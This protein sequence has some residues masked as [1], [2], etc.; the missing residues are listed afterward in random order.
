MRFVSHDMSCSMAG[1]GL[2]RIPYRW[3]TPIFYAILVKLDPGAAQSRQVRATPSSPVCASI[4]STSAFPPRYHVRGQRSKLLFWASTARSAL[5]IVR[6]RPQGLP[7]D[8]GDIAEI[9]LP[10]EIVVS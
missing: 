2:A 3:A 8:R 5:Q 4:T 1:Y 9:F 10:S 7:I 6:P